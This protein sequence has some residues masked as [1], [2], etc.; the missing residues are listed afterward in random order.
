MSDENNTNMYI[1]L[2][3]IVAFI[4]YYYMF[5]MTP[6]PITC[7]TGYILKDG[8]CVPVII[9]PA[10]PGAPVGTPAPITC[11]TGY[12]LKDGKCV[13]VPVTCQIG[14]EMKN[15]V[16]TDIECPAGEFLHMG[17]CLV[18]KNYR[19]PSTSGNIKKMY[20]ILEFNR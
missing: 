1:G 4:V 2:A 18:D 20:D 6:A 17:T 7:D 12:I 5:M 19:Q 15:G 9:T 10:A 11:D 14:F 13:L 8:K 3:V 16:C